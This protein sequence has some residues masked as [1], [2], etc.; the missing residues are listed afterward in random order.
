M[1]GENVCIELALKAGRSLLDGTD[2]W[3]HT[4]CDM[5]PYNGSVLPIEGLH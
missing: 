4:M 5:L 2:S 1:P 3:Q